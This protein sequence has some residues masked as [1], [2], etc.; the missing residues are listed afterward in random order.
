[1]FNTILFG[2]GGQALWALIHM[3]C[4]VVDDLDRVSQKDVLCWMM[5]FGPEARPGE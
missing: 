5:R 1:M 3:P 4:H 2:S